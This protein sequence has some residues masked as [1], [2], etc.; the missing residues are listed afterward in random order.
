MFVTATCT[1]T[2]PFLE[3]V[4]HGFTGKADGAT[5]QAGLSMNAAGV[6]YGTANT[7]GSAMKGTL[8][9]LNWSFTK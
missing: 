1:S 7:G 4:L 9:H 8:F 6:L 5:P 2:T 3:T